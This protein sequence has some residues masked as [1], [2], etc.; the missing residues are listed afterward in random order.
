[1]AEY[2]NIL[3]MSILIVIFFFGGWFPLLFFYFFPNWFNMIIKINFIVYFF[4]LIR[5]TLPRYR[6]DQLMDIGWKILL[7]FSLVFLLFYSIFIFLINV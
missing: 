5:A 6:Y 4:I 1:L 7:P 3:I 2:S